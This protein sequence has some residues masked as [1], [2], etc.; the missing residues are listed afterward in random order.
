LSL[1]S[2]TANAATEE[3]AAAKKR[4]WLDAD[5]VIY[6]PSRG[7]KL[8]GNLNKANLAYHGGPVITSA[9]VVFI[10]WGP[11]FNNAASPDYAYARTLQNFR[12]QL[13][14]TPEYNVITQY[15]GIQ[16]ANL[17]AGS[18]DWFDTSTPPTNVTDALVQSKV[19]SY[20]AS[21]TF[22][23]SAIYEVVIPSS[24]YSSSGTSTS[25]GGTNLQYCAY[26]GWIGSGAS[27]TKYSIQPYPS[28]AG[29]QAAGW[30][31]AQNQE[32]F[33]VHETREAVTDATGTGWFD[34]AAE[35][36][37]K[38]NWSPTP[39]IGT[40]GYGY[41]YEWSNASSSCVQSVAITQATCGESSCVSLGGAYIS[42]FTGYNCTGGES[43]YTPYFGSDGIRRSWNGSGIAGTVLRTVTNMSYRDSS[44][45]CNNAWT[46]G[47]TLSG[48]VAIYRSGTP[49]STTCGE[50]S[51]VALGGAYI[52][53]YT[54]LNCTG[55]ESYYTP[56]FSSDGIRRSWDGNGHAGTILRTATNMSYRDSSGTCN[57]AWPSGNTLSGFVLIYR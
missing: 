6:T 42:H 25:C 46:S 30:S 38:C 27:A 32:H 55:T 31:D 1:L 22:D 34:G 24:S 18:V 48:F 28:C 26:H 8:A 51:C 17:G 3:R 13:G 4:P 40:G 29:C 11:G 44:G 41:Q 21:H 54:G 33:V 10:F 43:Y 47:N 49:P 36:D 20:L 39:F 56:Y 14:T 16:L 5:H 52:S 45:T 23:A 12:N 37:D 19:N 53:H 7:S 2:V 50:L 9:K 35:A 15:S 57:N